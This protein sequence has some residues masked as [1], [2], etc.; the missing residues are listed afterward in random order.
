M[1]ECRGE[2]ELGFVDEV[3]LR[4]GSDEGVGGEVLGDG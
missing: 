3:H 1:E 4:G 2:E